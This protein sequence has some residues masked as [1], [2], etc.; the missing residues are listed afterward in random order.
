[1]TTKTSF[2]NL[3]KLAAGQCSVCGTRKALVHFDGESFAVQVRDATEMVP[4][5]SGD[6]CSACEEVFLDSAS[7]LLFADAGDDLVLKLRKTEG[8][9]LR[10]ARVSLGLSQADAGILAGG[11]HNGF[12]RYENGSAVPVTAV[13]NLFYLLERHPQLASDLPGVTVKVVAGKTGVTKKVQRGVLLKGKRVVLQVKEVAKPQFVLKRKP[14]VDVGRLVAAKS[15]QARIERVKPAA[16]TSTKK[17]A[18]R[19]SV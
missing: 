9:K 14:V 18:S 8:E 17:V 5:L 1:M 15:T 6:R 13:W 12:S 3:P 11:G 7:A 10:K 19:R 4:D 16:K 2:A